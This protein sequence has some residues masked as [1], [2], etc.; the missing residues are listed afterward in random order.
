VD[1]HD[2]QPSRGATQELSWLEA[3]ACWRMGRFRIL[4][5]RLCRLF[6]MGSAYQIDTVRASDLLSGFGCSSVQGCVPESSQGASSRLPQH[7]ALQR[8][9][10]PLRRILGGSKTTEPESDDTG[11]HARDAGVALSALP[12]A[13]GV[14]DPYRLSWFEIGGL[15]R[16]RPVRQSRNLA[17][18][19]PP[20]G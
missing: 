15:R 4:G 14:V 8:V 5:G 12:L 18:A 17:E 7:G 9:R 20:G 11:P 16:L 10:R 13:P 2:R 1:Q 3:R 19:C 6:K